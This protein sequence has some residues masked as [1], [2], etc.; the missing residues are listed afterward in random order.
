[1]SVFCR[2]KLPQLIYNIS[3]SPRCQNVNVELWKP[4][5]CPE[6]V[7]IQAA[8]QQPLPCIQPLAALWC[9]SSHLYHGETAAAC[10]K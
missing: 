10:G 2:F 7:P 1:M 9:V 5:N 8:E 6:N 4:V 3:K